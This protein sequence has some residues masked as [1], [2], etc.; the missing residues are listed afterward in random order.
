MF[1]HKSGP[2]MRTLLTSLALIAV[3]TYTYDKP[4]SLRVHDINLVGDDAWLAQHF[5]S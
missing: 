5:G 4:T 2:W 3:S 1:Y